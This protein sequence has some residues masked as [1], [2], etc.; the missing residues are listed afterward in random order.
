LSRLI[1]TPGAASGLERCRL[2]L[3][4]KSAQASRRAAQ[5]IVRQFELLAAQPNMGRPLE[6]QPDLRELLIAFGDS[7]YVALYHYEQHTDAVLILAFRHQK[8]AGY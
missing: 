8:E 2:F 3:G 6:D 5:T 7:G 1:V 4:Q